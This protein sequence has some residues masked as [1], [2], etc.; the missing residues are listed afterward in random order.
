MRP[1]LTA[2]LY[3]VFGWHFK[4]AAASARV[5]EMRLHDPASYPSRDTPPPCPLAQQASDFEGA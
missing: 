3:K 1:S 4:H 2:Q 5:L